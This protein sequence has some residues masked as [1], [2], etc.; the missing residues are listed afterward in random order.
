MASRAVGAVPSSTRPRWAANWWL[1]GP[2]SGCLVAAFRS[3]RR[4]PPGS[5]SPRSGDR[6]ASSQ[7]PAGVRF[8]WIP[9]RPGRRPPAQAMGAM[10]AWPPGG[11]GPAQLLV[12]L[13]RS[14]CLVDQMA[15]SPVGGWGRSRAVL[16]SLD[17]GKGRASPGSTDPSPALCP[18]RTWSWAKGQLSWRWRR[19]GLLHSLLAPFRGVAVGE[20]CRQVQGPRS[21]A[22]RGALPSVP[23]GV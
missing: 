12:F 10:E 6:W 17:P 18:D 7:R 21:C 13:R 2:A 5:P 1:R 23:H 14:L 9:A 19:G 16:A 3:L 15:R 11:P 8:R 20:R 22:E 4:V